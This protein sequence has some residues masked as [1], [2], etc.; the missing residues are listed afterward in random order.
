MPAARYAKRRYSAAPSRRPR[1]MARRI[2]SASRRKLRAIANLRTGGTLGIEQ[3]YYDS[4]L[5][6]SNIL[7]LTTANQTAM[8]FASATPVV[9]NAVF[10]NNPTVGSAATQRDGRVIRNKSIEVQGSVH[11]RIVDQVATGFYP[12]TVWVALVLDTQVNAT[13]VSLSGAGPPIAYGANVYSALTT[14]APFRNLDATT[15]FRVLAVKRIQT[16]SDNVP[17]LT[18]GYVT[19]TQQFPFKL[20]RKL[21]FKTNFITG[22]GGSTLGSDIVDN[23]IFL[24][25]WCDDNTNTT[26]I[27]EA[28]ARLRFVG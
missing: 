24:M 22:A 10:L 14:A 13:A 15:R 28:G 16:R 18:A 25:A 1:R 7:P 20:Y 2:P 19:G 5:A 23:G 12:P 11:F 6:G 26:L 8:P 21:G 3:K 27:L 4:T 9:A 17:G